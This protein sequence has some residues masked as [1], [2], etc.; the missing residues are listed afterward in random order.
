MTHAEFTN[1]KNC[2]CTYY[3][4]KSSPLVQ[5]HCPHPPAPCALWDL[6]TPETAWRQRGSWEWEDEV[7]NRR[8]GRREG[9]LPVPVFL[10]LSP[11]RN[12]ILS[13]PRLCILCIDW[14]SEARRH[15][16]AQTLWFKTLCLGIDGESLSSLCWNLRSNA[17]L[18][19]KKH[20]TPNNEING[21]LLNAGW[22]MN[23]KLLLDYTS[24]SIVV[25]RMIF[26]VWV[27]DSLRVNLKE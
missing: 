8:L 24:L 5:L 17:K 6:T 19:G 11:Q 3:L 22:M 1:I 15:T 14:V 20:H 2:Q 9:G 25:F 26:N 7:T 10:S 13:K 21:N 12:L 23:C 18:W 4:F 27:N 16:Q